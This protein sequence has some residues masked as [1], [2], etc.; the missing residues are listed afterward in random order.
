MAYYAYNSAHPAPQAISGLGAYYAWGSSAEL[1]RP[2]N[3]LASTDDAKLADE[4]ARERIERRPPVAIVGEWAEQVTDV[5]WREVRGG[6][7][8]TLLPLVDSDVHAVRQA[9]FGND[10]PVVAVYGNR[11]A[12]REQAYQAFVGTPYT[13]VA[14]VAVYSVADRGAVADARYL[15]VAAP[16]EP[17]DKDGGSGS[18]EQAAKK[19]SG[20]LCY[21]VSVPAPAGTRGPGAPFMVARDRKLNGDACA[22]EKFETFLK[23]ASAYQ[24]SYDFARSRGFGAEEIAPPADSVEAAVARPTV[25]HAAWLLG[26]MAAAGLGWLLLSKRGS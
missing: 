10:L 9:A 21:L 18:L 19:L 25:K 24:P 26:G 22:A 12:T 14:A 2:V 1:Y 5:S 11:E 3:G 6:S 23:T 4:A 15:W 13:L 8:L 7:M 17:G 20:V 16:R